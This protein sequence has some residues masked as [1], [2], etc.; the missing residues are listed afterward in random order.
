MKNGRGFLVGF[1]KTLLGGCL[2]DLSGQYRCVGRCHLGLE[3]QNR[4]W[5]RFIGE[6]NQVT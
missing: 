1:A 2:G 3:E 6:Y 4:V 5:G